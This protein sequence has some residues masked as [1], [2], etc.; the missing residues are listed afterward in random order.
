MKALL[1]WGFALILMTLTFTAHADWLE[2][3]KGTVTYPSGRVDNINFDFEYKTVFDEHYF[4]AG[5]SQIHVD[6]VPPNYILNM[7]INDAGN[8]YVAEFSN[9]F[10][11]GFDFHLGK[12]RVWVRKLP[13]DERDG[14]IM[15]DFLVKIDDKDYLFNTTHPTVIFEFDENG[16]AD[17]SGSGYIKDLDLHGGEE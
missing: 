12:H 14:E 7:I 11:H 15:G 3:G 10:L 1:Q 16:V 9:G 13:E 5:Q 2:K 4:R 8:I 6:E 17:I